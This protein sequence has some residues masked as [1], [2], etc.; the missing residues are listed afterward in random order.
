MVNRNENTHPHLELRREEPVPRRR[1]GGGGGNTEAPEDPAGHGA[2][3]SG[4][5]QTARQN[6]VEDINGYDERRLI[7]ITLSEKA[8]PEQISSAAV[9]VEIIS[10][11]EDTLVLAF[12]TDE[13]L[14]KF[15]AKLN[16][17][18]DGKKVTYANVIYAMQDFDR[19]TPDDRT[20]W[21]L[22]RD[23]FPDQEQFALDVELWPLTQNNET[24]R[25]RQAFVTWLQA[26]GG[27]IIDSVQQPY[28]TVY[29]VRTTQS[30]ANEILRYRDVR[31]LDL[32]ARI[33]LEPQVRFTEIQQLR[34]TPAPQADAPGIATLDS[35][36]VGGHPLLAPA[37][38]DSQSFIAG[39]GAD[40]E[41]GH[42][43]SVSGIALYDDI[44]DCIRDGR[45]VPELRLFSGRILDENNQG[46]PPLIHNQIASAVRYFTE[47][48][49]CRVFNLSYGDLNK[50]YQ[51]GHVAGLAVTLDALQREFDVL[52]VVPTGN[53]E[54]NED[55]R[56]DWRTNY[57]GYLTEDQSTLIDPAT[58]LNALTVG[59]L[60]RYEKG[61]P[62]HRW[63]N[64]PAYIAIAKADQPSPFTRHGPS[65]NGA[66]K[67]DLVDYGGNILVDSRAG[68]KR[69]LGL[70]GVGEITTSRNFAIGQPFVQESG[71]SFAAPRVA[72]LAAKILG[73]FP[74]ASPDLC[75]ALLVAHSRTPPASKELYAKRE[76]TLTYVTG[77]GRVDRTGLFRSL[78]S[79]VTLWTE[80][81]IENRR[82][83]FYQIPIPIEFW[84]GDKRLR[85]LTVA[86]AFR[87][88][89]RTTRID[90]RA[91]SLRFKLVRASSLDD[92][93]RW[94]NADDTR[95]EEDSKKA[96]EYTG[97]REL[98]ETDR[99]RG[100]VQASTWTFAQPSKATSQSSWFVV[101][102]RNDPGWGQSLSYEREPYSL[103]VTLSDR[104]GQQ[105]R[106][107]A[108]SLYAQ[109][110]T[111]LQG[112]GRS[113]G[114]ARS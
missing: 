39:K 53:Y 40:D 16:D 28:L 77:Y 3:L 69:M 57:P 4:R 100:T 98:T 25:Q 82:N 36:L 99:S 88:A 111:L 81:R 55:C 84:D 51:G 24:D 45:F 34:P 22:R 33:G 32:P 11:E 97:G 52:F 78:D 44:A 87:P 90:Y 67:P 73:E 58:A 17:I 30:L 86:L 63:P 47:H 110:Q 102:T 113:R 37:V 112:R 66:I 26:N 35:G 107:G 38:G 13:E 10:Q 83:H 103:V 92:V 6:V 31:S 27:T 64:D 101:V 72:N 19:W 93:V 104:A 79:F 12:A 21:A 43:T 50:P 7:K 105:S 29:R 68:Y 15:E 95:S 49:D 48:Y 71:T 9:G 62:N 18:S 20:G 96:K 106:L 56:T 70:Q 91:S 8:S 42:G 114:R 23:G 54:G 60:A 46:D 75:R 109:V 74:D 94:F 89:V 5:L 41:H 2:R 85:E 76:E 61:I 14:E 108:R 65:V 1:P 80:E 59:S